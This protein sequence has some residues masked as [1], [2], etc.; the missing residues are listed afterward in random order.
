MKPGSVIFDMAVESGGNV[1]G[2]VADEVIVRNGVKI[3]GISNL[4]SSVSNHASLAL[5]NNYIHWIKDFYDKDK[6][7]INFDFNDE[8]IKSSVLVYE[9]DILNE[10]FK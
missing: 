5:S 4:A 1:E 6:A 10:R 9:N 8:I 7:S 3:I 2:S